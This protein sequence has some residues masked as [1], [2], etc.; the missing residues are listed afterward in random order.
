[1]QASDNKKKLGINLLQLMIDVI[2]F[3]LRF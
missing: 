2:I 3:D 1:V